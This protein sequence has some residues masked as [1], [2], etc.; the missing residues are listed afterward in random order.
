M[1]KQHPLTREM[2]QGIT[3]DVANL[4]WDD[5]DD[6]EDYI[7]ARRFYDKGAADRLQQV[8]KWL[9]A[10]KSTVKLCPSILAA[11]LEQAMR[12]QKNTM[13]KPKNNND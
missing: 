11:Q 5:R 10:T 9:K 3:E 1:T 7:L 12:P 4:D 8:A 2:I 6:K 13:T